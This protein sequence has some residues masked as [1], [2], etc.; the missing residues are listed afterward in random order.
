MLVLSSTMQIHSSIRVH[1][2][3]QA[4]TSDS[5]LAT[6]HAVLNLL[7]AISSNSCTQSCNEIYNTATSKRRRLDV[8]QSA[9]ASQFWALKHSM[10]L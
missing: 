5:S 1:P 3:P 2:G 6:R 7:K 8:P 4:S 10:T 9:S